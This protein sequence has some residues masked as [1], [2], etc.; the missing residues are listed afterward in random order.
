MFDL[1]KSIADWREQMLAAGI[2]TPVPLEELE[3]H[4]RDEIEQRV[5]SGLNG[6][7]AF[8]FAVQKIG[9]GKALKIEF[10]KTHK[11]NSYRSLAWAAW[12]LFAISLVLPAYGQMW[13]W[14]CALLSVGAAVSWEEPAGDWASI[15]LSVLTL[16]NL[17]MIVSPFLLPRFLQNARSLKWLRCS[18]FLALVLVWSYLLIWFAFEKSEYLDWKRFNIGCYVWAASFLL[19][20]LSTFQQRSEKVQYV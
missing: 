1:E 17:L 20:F 15:H 3:I 11:D 14:R 8:N 19:L 12:I 10:Q 9:Q 6:Q 18:I 7:E 5:K 16:A 13:G 2:K 4:L